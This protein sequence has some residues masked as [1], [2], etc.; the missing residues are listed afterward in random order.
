MFEEFEGNELAELEE[1]A[2]RYRHHIC[3]TAS[4]A[5]FPGITSAKFS[6]TMRTRIRS[7]FCDRQ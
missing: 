5:N 2:R 4:L 3:W 7:G 1:I 6:Q